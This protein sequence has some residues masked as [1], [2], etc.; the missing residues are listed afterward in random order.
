VRAAPPLAQSQV[1]WVGRLVPQ[2]APEVMAAAGAGFAVRMLG[3]G[4]L[5]DR[6]HAEPF[7]A[8]WWGYLHTADVFVSTSRFE[9]QPNTVLEAMAAECPLVV[10][11]LPAHREILD[12]RS[13]R[14]VPPDDA[15]ALASALREVLADRGAARER[16]RIARERVE[17]RT[18]A[19]T[20]DAYEAVYA[21]V[22]ARAR[23]RVRRTPARS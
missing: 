7:R 8:D 20:A 15:P 23:P 17:T 4:P 5:R 12:D 10:T 13:A 16:A 3:D 9:G 18:I 14:F 1:L 21:R 6:C 2:K 22:L 19:R 11:D